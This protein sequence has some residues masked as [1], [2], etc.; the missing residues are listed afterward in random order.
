MSERF[1]FDA[2]ATALVAGYPFFRSAISCFV[3]GP[4]LYGLFAIL[5]PCQYLSA[6][7]PMLFIRTEAE[8]FLIQV[9]NLLQFTISP[10]GLQL[11]NFTK[12]R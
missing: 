6:A 3:Y 2:S 11:K 10:V 5:V 7:A 1:S 9:R 4:C 12:T 8:R